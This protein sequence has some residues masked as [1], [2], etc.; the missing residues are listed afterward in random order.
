MPVLATITTISLLTGRGRQEELLFSNPALLR[1]R[2]KE[3][4]GSESDNTLKKSLAIAD[5]LENF[6]NDYRASVESSFDAYIDEASNRYTSAPE[7]IER[8]KPLDRE[9]TQTLQ[10]VIKLRQSLIQLLSEGQWKAVFS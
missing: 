5:E 8:L 2:L 6:L 9:R 3:A 1:S 4:L 7:L 10:Q